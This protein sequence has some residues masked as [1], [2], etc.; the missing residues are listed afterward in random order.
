MK[1]S[2]AAKLAELLGQSSSLQHLNLSGNRLE[3]AGATKL[4]KGLRACSKLERLELQSNRSFCATTTL[5]LCEV[6]FPQMS[7][8][9]SDVRM[10]PLCTHVAMSATERMPLPGAGELHCADFPE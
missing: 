5:P 7:C 8:R 1:D 6:A 9:A 3:V 4:A 2:A 10:I